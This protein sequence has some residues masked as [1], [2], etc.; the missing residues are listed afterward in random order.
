MSYSLCFSCSEGSGDELRKLL[1]EEIDT[2]NGAALSLP[3][4]TREFFSIT[5]NGFKAASEVLS[6]WL[7]ARAN[8]KVVVRHRVGDDLL[9]LEIQNYSA[10]EIERILSSVQPYVILADESKIKDESVE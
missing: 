8:R 7:T 5:C 10:K 1:A 2:L 6:T 3:T 9:D 4:L